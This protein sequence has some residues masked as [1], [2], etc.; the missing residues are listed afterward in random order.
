MRRSTEKQPARQHTLAPSNRTDCVRVDDLADPGP[1]EQEVN[2]TPMYM[3]TNAGDT[4]CERRKVDHGAPTGDR[5]TFRFTHIWESAAK[6]PVVRGAWL[7][8][9]LPFKSSSVFV[10]MNHFWDF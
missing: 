7:V 5:Q 8:R 10:R 6:K 2:M 9:E 4:R 1:L 3:H